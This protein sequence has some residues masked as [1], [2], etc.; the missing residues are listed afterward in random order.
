VK[1]VNEQWK[2]YYLKHVNADVIKQYPHIATD[3]NGE[4]WGYSN[5]PQLLNRMWERR[6]GDVIE[7][8][9]ESS[10]VDTTPSIDT[11][12][13]SYVDF[14][15]AEMK[16][17]NDQWKEFYKTYLPQIMA[18]YQPNMNYLACDAMGN[19]INWTENVPHLRHYHWYDSE[20]GKNNQLY[21][22]NMVPSRLDYRE[23]V[24]KLVDIVDWPELYQ[25]HN[26][27]PT[28]E[29]PFVATDGDGMV[30]LYGDK[31]VQVRTIWDTESRC[32]HIKTIDIPPHL[33][34]RNSLISLNE[35][36]QDKE[37]P[38]PTLDS[39]P[40]ISATIAE[41]TQLGYTVLKQPKK[42]TVSQKGGSKPME[43]GEAIA[44]VIEAGYIVL[45]EATYINAEW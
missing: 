31:P 23:S 8:C 39:K 42:L 24:V 10:S 1:T 43:H 36:K 25:M 2:E 7:L 16:T 22:D 37:Y 20:N 38:L 29:F 12:Q 45:N 21:V 35:Q 41:L 30:Y 19:Y 32:N 44:A 4:V 40:D 6:K 9:F 11:W 3:K 26:I 33:D 27:A 18:E 14:S 5:M 28:A 13:D 15:E 34:Y 17:V